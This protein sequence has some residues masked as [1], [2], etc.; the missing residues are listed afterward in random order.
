MVFGIRPNWTLLLLTTLSF[1]VGNFFLFIAAVIFTGLVIFS[2]SSFLPVLVISVLGLL[3]FWLGH[4]LPGK[5]FFNNSFILV[6]GTFVFY[7]LT[8]AVFLSGHPSLVTAEALI[9]AFFGSLFFLS[10]RVLFR[11]S[12]EK[13]ARVAIR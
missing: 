2:A 11:D 6:L 12:H 3:A 13:K 1:F 4:S 10:L 9:N 7:G 8:N 5:P